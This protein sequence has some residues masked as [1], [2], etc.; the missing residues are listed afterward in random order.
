MQALAYLLFYRVYISIKKNIIKTNFNFDKK[1]YF[2]IDL[3]FFI[4]LLL[5]LLVTITYGFKAGRYQE[6]S[7]T[8]LF[9]IMQIN[10]IFPFYYALN[11]Q[12]GYKVLFFINTFLFSLIFIIQ[13][14]TGILL[15]IAFIE[16]Y[17]RKKVVSVLYI[18]FIPLTLIFLSFIYMYI[19][20]IKIA[21][22]EGSYIPI[23]FNY[24]LVL[25]LGRISLLSNTYV[26]VQNIDDILD[27]I[28]NFPDLFSILRAIRILIPKFLA[29]K[30][31]PE[32]VAFYNYNYVLA[33]YRS[34]LP[35]DAIKEFGFSIT[36]QIGFVGIIYLLYKKS[37]IEL[38]LYIEFVILILL[39]IF[40]ILRLFKH[41]E[42]SFPL[43][44]TIIYFAE[45]SS[46]LET[47]TRVAFGLFIFYTLVLMSKSLAK[48]K[49]GKLS[50]KG[51]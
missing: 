23:D 50:I 42:L 3:F 25:F 21:I 27:L 35:I 17:I 9:N 33:I 49:I 15:Y 36:H 1:V 46:V 5:L 12:N 45:E 28:R 16:F 37:I 26:I 14:F 7:L 31:F 19:Y 34:G 48:L 8:I 24:A 18:L 40:L 47:L 44:L 22:R 4:Y 13:G 32:E 2:F 43:W 41:K 10:F 30:I 29:E 51:G 11:R 38:I 20:P 6:T 39:F